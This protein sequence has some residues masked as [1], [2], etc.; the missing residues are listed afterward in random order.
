MRKIILLFLVALMLTS[1]MMG[2]NYQRPAVDSPQAWRFEDKEAK[3]TANTAWWEQFN[4]PVLNDLI[5]TA[6][7]ENKDVKTAAAK[8]EQFV[9]QYGT[10]RAALFPQ[11]SAGATYGRQRAS[12]LTGP[13]PLE[14]TGVDP[15]FN[16]SQLFLNAAW[17]I[18]LWGK[19]RRS[20]EAA[21]A[22]LLSTEEARRTV[23]L[24]LVTSV[25]STYIDLRDL[26]K[27][28]E[29]AKQ[30]AKSREESYNLFKLR[31]EGGV[32]SELE[33]NQVKSEYE[34]ALSTIP[35]FEKSIAQTENSLC[36]LLGRNPG[37]IARGKTIDQLTLP[38][39]PSGLPSDILTNRPDIR[40]AE[41]NL[42]SANANIGVA[43]ALYFPS[44][45]LTGLLG[46]ES[47][48]LSDLFKGPA[49]TWSWA[50][51][52]S[53]PIFTAGQIAGQVKAAEALQQQA[54]FTYEKSIQ[55]AFREVD[56]ALIDQKKSREQIEAQGRQVAS[57][58]D[59]ARIARLRY[60]NGYTSYIEVLDAER[61]LF[62]A[63]LSYTQTQGTLF[64][65]L[66]NLYKS[67]GG[68][69]VVTADVFT[70]PV[71]GV[72]VAKGT[73]APQ[74]QPASGAGK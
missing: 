19:L 52:A 41:Q 73:S 66:V 13:S 28:L 7:K 42:I 15:T 18:D 51:P 71:S 72:P 69:W 43:K 40:Q 33:L 59:Y 61:S 38:A 45:S 53:M 26:D 31:F 44:I 47:K 49:K 27:Q 50:V 56:D 30:T 57:L 11:V 65:A 36:T 70:E 39:V 54:L 29:I 46:L 6:L 3:D 8:V 5:L 74:G 62:N 21:R 23:I 58:R 14:H 16:S 60:D 22:D 68:G 1:C 9:G 37:A 55:E 4:D 12:E 63:E 35:Q 64:L 67:M 48:D 25:A 24:T 2:P 20:T 10:T 32:I 34:Q 17:E